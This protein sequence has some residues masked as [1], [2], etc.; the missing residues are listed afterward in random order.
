MLLLLLQGVIGYKIESFPGFGQ[1]GTLIDEIHIVKTIIRNTEFGD[2]FEGGIHLME[3]AFFGCWAFI[4]GHGPWTPAKRI[5][6]I[7][8]EAVPVGHR[9]AE[10]FGHGFISYL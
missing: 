1:R 3:G 8:A 9:K 5:T 7:S 4:P 10:M 2:K 6:T